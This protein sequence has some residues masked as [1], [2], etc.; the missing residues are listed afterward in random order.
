MIEVKCQLC[1]E[2]FGE[3][4]ISLHY[5]QKHKEKYSKYKD[6]NVI[7]N[8]DD[9]IKKLSDEKDKLKKDLDAK[10]IVSKKEEEYIAP[11]KETF[12]ENQTVETPSK[13]NIKINNDVSFY[14]Y[15]FLDGSETTN[16][17]L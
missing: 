11:K 10:K 15:T 2:W 14:E 3:K 16:E 12:K 9:E 17:W 1:N 6:K 8:V 5:W 4:A 7:R 13:K